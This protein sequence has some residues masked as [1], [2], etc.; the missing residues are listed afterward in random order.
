MDRRETEAGCVAR[1]PLGNERKFRIIRYVDIYAGLE[2]A[3]GI[4][5]KL[6]QV[7]YSRRREGWHE[8]SSSRFSGINWSMLSSPISGDK[9]FIVIV[10][11]AGATIIESA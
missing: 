11:K 8:Q 7:W 10:H 1:M 6:V 5:G 2:R 3:C 4:L 9:F